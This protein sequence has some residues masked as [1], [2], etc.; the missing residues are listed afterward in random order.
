MG[1]SPQ[2]QDRSLY[3]ETLPSLSTQKYKRYIHESS[4]SHCQWICRK[5]KLHIEPEFPRKGVSYMSPLDSYVKIVPKV[6]LGGPT[7]Y[8]KKWSITVTEHWCALCISQFIAKEINQVVL[9]T[10][11]FEFVAWP[12]IVCGQESVNGAKKKKKSKLH[13]L[14][15]IQWKATQSFQGHEIVLSR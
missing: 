9:L 10:V 3:N 4:I 11:R 12:T 2:C 8:H 7:W 14:I 5:S 13:N 6:L 1:R 15:S